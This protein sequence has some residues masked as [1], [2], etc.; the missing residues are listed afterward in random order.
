MSFFVATF[1][2]VAYV[3]AHISSNFNF[4]RGLVLIKFGSNNLAINKCLNQK[5]VFVRKC[6]SQVV[7]KKNLY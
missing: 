6:L 2:N 1:A 5:N 3:P 7:D 4:K